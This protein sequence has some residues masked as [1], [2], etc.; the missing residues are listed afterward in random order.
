MDVSDDVQVQFLGGTHRMERRLLRVKLSLLKLALAEWRSAR[1]VKG[2]SLLYNRIIPEVHAKYL[3]PPRIWK[4]K[5][6]TNHRWGLQVTRKRSQSARP[7]ITDWRSAPGNAHA[8]ECARAMRL[9]LMTTS[10]VYP[11]ILLMVQFIDVGAVANLSGV[12][13]NNETKARISLSTDWLKREELEKTFP[14]P[15]IARINT[16]RR[17]LPKNAGQTWHLI[18]CYSCGKLNPG[19]FDYDQRYSKNCGRK[20]K[21]FSEKRHS[22]RALKSTDEKNTAN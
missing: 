3:V 6:R 7:W 14:L 9:E 22:G 19:K 10:T 12:L 1:P 20:F 16:N 4:I 13:V 11:T 5:R 15:L 21:K 2:L 18:E 17:K 8:H